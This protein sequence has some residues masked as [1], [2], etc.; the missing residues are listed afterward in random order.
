MYPNGYKSIIFKE[1]KIEIYVFHMKT[2][3]KC[4]LFDG[5]NRRPDLFHSFVI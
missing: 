2:E 1:K 4:K 3:V 5:I